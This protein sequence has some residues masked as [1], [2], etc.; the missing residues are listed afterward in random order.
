M[1]APCQ[2][3]DLPSIDSDASSSNFVPRD[4]EGCW[5]IFMEA[6]LIIRL[7]VGLPAPTSTGRLVS[8]KTARSDSP[9]P[10]APPIHH[11]PTHPRPWHDRR[12]SHP[13]NGSPHNLDPDGTVAGDG[14][15]GLPHTPESA[16][17]VLIPVPWEATV[18]CGEGAAGGPAAIFAASQQ[19][20]LFDI[21]AGHPWESGIAMLP[22]SEE[23]VT[24]NAAARRLAL[25]VIRAGGV[26]PTLPEDH[27]L[28]RRAAAVDRFAEQ[29]HDWVDRTANYWMDRGKRVGVV[30]GEHSAAFGLIRASAARHTGLGIL[31]IDAHAD[32]R[33]S[34]EGFRW[35]HASVMRNVIED[36]P[37]VATLVQVG[38]RDLAPREYAFFQE[39][40][41]RI[42]A[43]FEPDVRHRLHDGEPWA[44][45]AK[46]M[47]AA[48][49]ALVHVS[50]DID[51]LDPSLCPHTGTP[52]PG[53]LSFAEAVTL[54]RVLAESGRR[55]VSFDLCEVAPDA[56]GAN[57]W[58]GNVGARIL[59]KLI[60]LAQ[61]SQAPDGG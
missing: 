55:V 15:F 35:S 43:W 1:G 12:M 20:D 34:Y 10:H 42:R 22:V 56:T 9:P 6:D 27:D 41:P 38:V 32:L 30:G 59:Y 17:A 3:L 29:A 16:A 44:V 13:T 11:L 47:V 33:A 7:D 48:L 18:C 5:Q 40:A 57:E 60:G 45:V 36:L 50:F 37:A 49:P 19:V 8:D 61:R 4:I 58:D 14:I 53:G 54:F 52:V 39:H 31:Q 26:D 51:G 46:E 28:R 25:P 2:P 21:E 24:W 23:V